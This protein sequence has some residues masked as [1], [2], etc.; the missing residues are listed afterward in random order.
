MSETIFPELAPPTYSTPETPATAPILKFNEWQQ[1]EAEGIED[2]KDQERSYFDYFRLEKFKR[3]EL[4]PSTEADIRQLYFEN[5]GV[6]PDLSEEERSQIGL[7]ST[8]FKPSLDQQIELVKGGYG[9]K[10]I[11][12]FLISLK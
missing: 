7:Q 3:D 8:A 9:E 10:E 12:P 4:T 1:T 6:E 11:Q 2:L 5:L